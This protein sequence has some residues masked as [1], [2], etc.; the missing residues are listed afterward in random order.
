MQIPSQNI[1]ICKNCYF[2]VVYVGVFTIR[3]EFNTAV[4]RTREIPFT[5]DNEPPEH[6]FVSARAWLFMWFIQK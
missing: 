4:H 1:A 6:D 3:G 5:A 2:R